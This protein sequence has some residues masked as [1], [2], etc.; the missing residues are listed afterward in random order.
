MI[1]KT[2]KHG[3]NYHKYW[4]IHIIMA[5]LHH[6]SSG[7]QI[8]Q[9]KV[10][11]L[12]RTLLG[13]CTSKR[14]IKTRWTK[15]NVHCRFIINTIYC[16]LDYLQILK[17][18]CKMRVNAKTPNRNEFKITNSILNNYLYFMSFQNYFLKVCK[19]PSKGKMFNI[20]DASFRFSS[21]MHEI[22]GLLSLFLLHN[23]N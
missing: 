19:D 12:F 5:Y 15:R 8:P 20:R 22:T 14:C 4:K 1:S 17:I 23:V 7:M 21:H 6:H 18:A 2:L 13:L 9:N 3:V 16:K 11:I 10:A